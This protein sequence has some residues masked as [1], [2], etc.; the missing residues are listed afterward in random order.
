[1]KNIDASYKQQID[2]EAANKLDGLTILRFA[3]AFPS[4]GGIERYLDDLDG[5]LLNR[6]TVTIIRMYLS[7]DFHND[8]KQVKQVARGTLVKVPLDVGNTAKNIYTN[9][10]KQWK[11]FNFYIK[12]ILRDWIIYNP[13]L[14]KIIFSKIVKKKTPISRG[15]V[16]L[17]AREETVKVFNDYNVDLVAMHFVGGPDSVAVI[18]ETMKRKIPYFFLNHFSNDRFNHMSIREQIAD[19]VGVASVSGVGIPR[20]LKKCFSNLSDGIDIDI[21][22]P[23]SASPIKINFD[24]PVIIL[25]ARIIPTKGQK[26]LIEAAA[27]L[28][29][30]G[31]HFKVVLAGRSDSREYEE[32]LKSQIRQFG[33]ENDVLFV[34][35]LETEE[36]RDWYNISSIMAFPT[37]HHEG[38]PRILMEA[39]A[40]KVP[41]VAYKIGGIPEGLQSGRTGYLVRKGDLKELTERLRQLLIDEPKRK[42]MGEKGRQFIENNF[43]L[44]AL[45]NRHEEFYLRVIKNGERV[46]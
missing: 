8:K 1:M 41:P 28:K 45:A 25:P 24:C 37:Y 36:L 40:M 13:F 44:A 3:R 5:Q 17:N 7:N 32:E 10:Q 34:G 46:M 27:I 20:R 29:N 22:K 39:Q 21:F 38:L 18:D 26:D 15:L 9:D 11:G 4:G 14:Y 6:N 43:S 16:A 2:T 12:K 35:Q 30:Q 31:L 42:K 33:M 19:A 23:E